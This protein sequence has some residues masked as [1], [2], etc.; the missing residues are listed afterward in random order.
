MDDDGAVRHLDEEALGRRVAPK[1][2]KLVLLLDEA[3]QMN[4]YDRQTHQRFRSLFMDTFAENLAAVMAGTE[5]KKKWEGLTS[6][7]YNFFMDL[8]LGPLTEKEAA[9]L[10]RRP[11]KGLYTYEAEAVRRVLVYSEM[12]PYLIQKYCALSVDRILDQKCR[13]ITADEVEWVR[14]Q[15]QGHV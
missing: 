13:N 2:L 15:L 6:P 10:I 4:G 3:D 11:V 8:A 1:E 9:E 12:R 7:W 14:S 5:I